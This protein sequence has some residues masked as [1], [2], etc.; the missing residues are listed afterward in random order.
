MYNIF[1]LPRPVT[2]FFSQ[3]PVRGV[4]E[5]YVCIFSST[6]VDTDPGFF[7]VIVDT[8]WTRVIVQGR[9]LTVHGERGEK[10]RMS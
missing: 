5:Y 6:P 10:R 7:A 1:F 8:K 3:Y 9:L 4:L 2:I